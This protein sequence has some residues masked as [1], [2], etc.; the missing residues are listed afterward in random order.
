LV[1]S[2]TDLY[3]VFWFQMGLYTVDK[4][5]DELIASAQELQIVAD[6]IRDPNPEIRKQAIDENLAKIALRL[7]Q[8][9]EGCEIFAKRLES[10]PDE[11]LKEISAKEK[12]IDELLDVA[13]AG[14]WEWDVETGKEI[15]DKHCATMAGYSLDELEQST[16]E[17]WDKLTHPDD[18]QIS[19]EKLQTCI[20]GKSDYYECELRTLHKDGHWIW[21]E[22]RGKVVERDESGRALRIVG[23]S[24]D[25]TE[26]KLDKEKIERLTLHDELTGVGNRRYLNQEIEKIERSG[27]RKHP[28]SMISIDIK[29]F[30]TVND[31]FGHPA[32]DKVLRTVATSLVEVVRPYDLV[33]RMG[34]DEFLIV[35]P[36]TDSEVA[37]E[38]LDRINNKMEEFHSSYPIRLS[39]GTGTSNDISG[40]LDDLITSADKKMYIH[41]KSQ[42]EMDDKSERLRP[43]IES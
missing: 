38:I 20:D 2:E 31:T 32:G 29:D 14:S 37:Q 27:G 35:L 25:V 13:N 26:K 8:T 5:E 42:L 1:N 9:D 19:Q 11:L 36:N 6:L 3:M 41:K 23:I 40:N 4:T 34:G 17:I 39:I 30:K 43:K 16:D 33:V 10:D 24:T 22:D 15:F 12:R 7:I 18:L 28:V 21:L